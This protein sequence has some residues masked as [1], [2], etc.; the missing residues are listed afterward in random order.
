MLNALGYTDQQL[1]AIGVS[2]APSDA[3][4]KSG[5]LAGAINDAVAA[6]GPSEPD[7]YLGVCN[8][9]LILGNYHAL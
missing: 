6:G 4:K 7:K 1:A 9:G 8:Y 3:F 2:A 5:I